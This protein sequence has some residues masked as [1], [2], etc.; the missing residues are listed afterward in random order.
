VGGKAGIRGE[1]QDVE[2][3]GGEALFA[4]LISVTTDVTNPAARKPPKSGAHCV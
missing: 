4:G 3:D 2:A 1:G